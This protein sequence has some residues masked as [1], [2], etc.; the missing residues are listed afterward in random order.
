MLKEYYD[1]VVVGGGPAGTM[2][3]AAAAAAGAKTLVLERDS[4]IGIPV[5]CG[6]A[7][8]IPQLER[9]FDIDEKYVANRIEGLIMHAPDGTSVQVESSEFG[10]VLERTRFDR[11]LAE[12][13]AKAG[14]M[15]QTRCEVTGLIMNGAG[16]EG[17]RCSR[18][19]KRFEIKSRVVIAADGVES[20]IARWVG[21]TTHLKPV[22]LESAYQF[23][24]AGIDVDPRYCH[25]FLGNDLAPGGYIWI[26]PKGDGIANVGIGVSTKICDGGTAYQKLQEFISKR[27]GDVAVI[28]EAAGGV[29]VARP[30]KKPVRDG[31]IVVGDAARYTNPLTGGGISNAMI[32]GK[33]A[34]EIAAKA[35]E[36][37]DVSANGLCEYISRIDRDIVK[38]NQR[39]YRLKEAVFKLRDKALNDTAHHILALPPKKRT[40]KNI[41]LKGLASQP[42][43]VLDIIKAFV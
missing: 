29:P 41:F 18:L 14:A 12:Y 10:L 39:A 38:S 13:A 25:F 11:M 35:V 6:E 34:G 16:V 15:L 21:I 27:Y 26:F 40:L 36:R 1:I 24:L 20:R 23:M 5:R 43:L 4:T 7:I 33:H 9:F 8:G 3:A 42:T 32:S 31:L 37:D 2:A 19:G 28:S 30:M 17:V 22:D